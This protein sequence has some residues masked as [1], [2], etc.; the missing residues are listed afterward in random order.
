MAGITLGAGEI[1]PATQLESPK[2]L[3]QGVDNSGAEQV[4]ETQFMTTKIKNFVWGPTGGEKQACPWSA[5]RV[6]LSGYKKRLPLSEGSGR[7]CSQGGC[8][9]PARMI[10][11]SLAHRVMPNVN[12]AAVEGEHC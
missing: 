3:R 2:V 12:L 9:C 5:T 1:Q 10:V 7:R 8:W 6:S 4:V 11:H